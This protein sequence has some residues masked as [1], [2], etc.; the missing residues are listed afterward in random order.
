MVAMTSIIPTIIN[1]QWKGGECKILNVNQAASEPN[2]VTLKSSSAL[3]G[4][5]GLC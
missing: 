3:V 4:R 5:Q 1:E 2:E